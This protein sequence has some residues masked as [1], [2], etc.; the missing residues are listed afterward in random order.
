MSG[1]GG[2][3]PED[4][5]DE[6]REG[7]ASPR[8]ILL[9]ASLFATLD[10]LFPVFLLFRPCVGVSMAAL[11]LMGPRAWPVA[12]LGTLASGLYLHHGWAEIGVDALVDTCQALLAWGL[13]KRFVGLPAPLFKTSHLLSFHLLI[14]PVA[15][16]VGTVLRVVGHQIFSVALP[17]SIPR[18]L[19][20]SWMGQSFGAVLATTIIISLFHQEYPW[21][22]RRISVALP[23]LVLLVLTFYA[24]WLV[25][26]RVE[27]L[28]NLTLSRQADQLAEE[29]QHEL[30]MSIGTLRATASFFGASEA[31]SSRELDHFVLSLIRGRAKPVVLAWVPR[32]TEKQ[33]MVHPDDGPSQE[34]ATSL[35]QTRSVKSALS[36]AG[37]PLKEG[38]DSPAAEVVRGEWAQSPLYVLAVPSRD[39]QG[40]HL[41]V[42]VGAFDLRSLTQ[43]ALAATI[44]NSEIALAL[45]V[46]EMGSSPLLAASASTFG[47]ERR[48]VSERYEMGGLTWLIQAYP[49]GSSP[50][51]PRMGLSLGLLM[52][53]FLLLF[54]LRLS[55]QTTRI[56]MLKRDIETRAEELRDLNSELESAVEASRR[57]DRAKSLFLANISHEIRTPMNGILGLTRLVLD[58]PLG[59]AQKEQ[60]RHVELSAQNLLA[61]FND[62]LDV[63]KMESSQAVVDRQPHNLSTLLQ[64]T[65][66]SLGLQAEEKN[67]ELIFSCAAEVPERL[68]IDGLKLRQ[69]LLNLLGNAIKFTPSG[70]EVELSVAL[71]ETKEKTATLRF[72]VRDSGRGIA[73]DQLE[74]IFLP[75]VQAEGTPPVGG[76]GL[77]L[78][79]SR[80]LVERMGGQLMVESR[81]GEGAT[82]TFTLEC[83]VEPSPPFAFPSLEVATL[84][85][86]VRLRHSRHRAVVEESLA[87]WGFPLVDDPIAARLLVVDEWEFPS[88][89]EDDRA[90]IVILPVSDLGRM[91][92]RCLQHGAVPLARPFSRHSLH[93]ALLQAL[94]PCAPP[95]ESPGEQVKTLSYRGKRALVVDDNLTNRLLATL[96]LQ[97]MGFSVDSLQDG[98]SALRSATSLTYDVILLDIR[99]PGLDG[100]EVAARLRGRGLRVPL[101]AAT[102]HAQDEHEE[103]ARQAGMDAF[104]TKPLDENRLREAVA[105][106][107]APSPGGEF[108]VDQLVRS[109]GGDLDSAREVIRGFLQEEAELRAALEQARTS[110]RLALACHTLKGA[111]EVFG[112]STLRKRLENLERR[113]ENGE[114]QEIGSSRD[115]V[116]E[117][118]AELVMALRTFLKESSDGG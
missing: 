76:S 43:S 12:A 29:L 27:A 64:E 109:V 42:V 36:R 89:L 108:E 48:R 21:N 87:S 54:F 6:L 66:R 93:Q 98:E 4:D 95:V 7:M 105:K 113:A 13:V 52:A 5:G 110:D 69:V 45:E 53:S 84:P 71:L 8:K 68:S 107:V 65:S 15:T 20:Y 90:A 78:A 31:V 81:E 46:E 17:Y 106:L 44:E 91:F 62:I 73:P 14:G 19:L 32:L 99:L 55:N 22:R 1:D 10:V 9:W 59:P 82:F 61:L 34:L 101:I 77:G 104:L 72:S 51:T 97:R 37:P 18:T 83:E 58:S 116:E 74:Q 56:E 47:K 41:G 86:L 11:F 80:A 79:I 38:T 63:S 50:E 28:R 117:E 60:L 115:D 96:L 57:A 2:K 88:T 85:T 49:V 112:M 67:V 33:G 35:S 100:Y 114:V 23:T 39:A 40:R 111:V 16:G 25:E 3:E 94:T 92:E 30:S 26:L 70:G 24:R 103:G 75:F 118:L 102:A